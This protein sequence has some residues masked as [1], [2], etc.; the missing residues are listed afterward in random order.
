MAM[1]TVKAKIRMLTTGEGGRSSPAASGYRPNLRFGDIYTDVSITRQ[2][3]QHLAPGEE[4][5]ATVVFANADQVREYL[6][7]GVEFDVTE[8]G[9]RVGAGTMSTGL[10]P[11]CLCNAVER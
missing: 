5:N 10:R 3:R 6:Q 4:C 1:I 8:G 2:D 9:R 7:V 11:S